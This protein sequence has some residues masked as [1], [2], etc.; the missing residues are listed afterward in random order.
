LLLPGSSSMPRLARSL[1]F[2]ATLASRCASYLRPGRKGG[3]GLASEVCVT[4]ESRGGGFARAHGGLVLR[5]L[6]SAFPAPPTAP[7]CL[8]LDVG[9]GSLSRLDGWRVERLVDPPVPLCRRLLAHP[10]PRA[11]LLGEFSFPRNRGIPH[12]LRRR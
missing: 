11:A 4:R 10:P 2:P 9:S 5:P 7:R 8:E 1:L 3:R 6:A 12:S